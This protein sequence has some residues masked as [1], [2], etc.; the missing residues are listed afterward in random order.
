MFMLSPDSLIMLA[1]YINICG[2]FLELNPCDSFFLEKNTL[3]YEIISRF[4]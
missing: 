4:F 1:L 2:M 3:T